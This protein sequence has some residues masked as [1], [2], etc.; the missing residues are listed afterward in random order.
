[1]TKSKLSI[2]VA[3]LLAAV[4]SAAP[5]EAQKGNGNGNGNG[6]NK[7]EQREDRRDRSD[8][9]RWERDDR[10]D[11]DDDRRVTRRRGDGDDRWT[12][13]R[14]R[15]TLSRNGRAVPKG[16]CQGR[17]NPHNTPANCGGYEFDTR[18]SV[19]EWIGLDRDSRRTSNRT[20]LGSTRTTSGSYSARHAEFHRQHD[21]RCREQANRAGSLAE[22]L[23]VAS[24][25]K[26]AHD[27]WHR[28]TGTRH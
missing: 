10:R 14:D 6:K 25:C 16:W 9:D 1:M 12:L 23:R 19:W 17:G 4:V 7:Q 20:V 3:L 18:R 21:A 24:Q 26:A 22:R 27:D 11:R 28:R 15:R 8:D 5:A 2:P 13:S